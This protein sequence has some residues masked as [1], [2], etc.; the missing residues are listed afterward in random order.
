MADGGIRKTGVQN[1]GHEKLSYKTLQN[2]TS[3][4]KIFLEAMAGQIQV[5]LCNRF[6]ENQNFLILE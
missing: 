3:F 6:D 1:H 2:T 5:I 4:T